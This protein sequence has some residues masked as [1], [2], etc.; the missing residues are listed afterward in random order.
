[1]KNSLRFLF[2]IG[3]ITTFGLNLN[4]CSKTSIKADKPKN[5]NKV[6]ASKIDSAADGNIA[7]F[8][9]PSLQKLTDQSP[10]LK[11]E[12]FGNDN[13]Q[14]RYIVGDIIILSVDKEIAY[15][16]LLPKTSED[17]NFYINLVIQ[18]KTDNIP[19][20]AKEWLINNEDGNSIIL[21]EF[22]ENYKDEILEILHKEKIQLLNKNLSLK[23]YGQIED[24]Y[25]K[26]T[27]RNIENDMQVL[28]KVQINFSNQK[29]IFLNQ[30]SKN[31]LCP[32]CK[33]LII[34]K[35]D[36]LGELSNHDN[37]TRILVLGFLEQIDQSPS[38][39]HVRLV[40]LE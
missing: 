29:S 39:L 3:V 26:S 6:V 9:M 23:P 13:E 34:F 36:F 40:N 10:I 35:G 1:M 25:F 27:Y 2:F 19:K 28:S 20:I 30:N 11:T 22:Y 32:E 38:A 18:N 8:Q 33:S 5:E 37:S 21:A 14:I 4:S 12:A 7:F 16:N 15:L 24:T 31:Q 17:D